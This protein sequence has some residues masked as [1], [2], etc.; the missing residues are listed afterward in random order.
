MEVSETGLRG[1]SMPEDDKSVLYIYET[2]LK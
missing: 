1:Y 2:E